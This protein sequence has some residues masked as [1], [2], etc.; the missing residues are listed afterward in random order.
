MQYSAESHIRLQKIHKL[1]QN[2]IIPYSNSFG[3]KTDIKDILVKEPNQKSDFLLQNGANG[4]YRILWRMILSRSHG[5]LSFAKIIDNTGSIQICLS[6][7]L[8]EI[9]NGAKVSKTIKIDENEI[10]AYNFFGKYVDVGDYVWIIGDFFVT[11]HWEKTLFVKTFS[12]LSKAIR[13]LPDKFHGINDIEAIYKQRYLDLITNED[14]YRRFVFRSEFVRLIREFYHQQ[15]F[16]E[17]TTPTLGNSASGAAAKPFVTYHND[18]KQN[19]FLRIAPEIAL[20]KATVWRFEKVF[21]FATNFRN[22]WSDPSHMQ[23]FCVVEHYA[24]WRN[25]EDNMIFTEKMFD[26]IFDKT[27]LSRNIKVKD[28]QWIEKVVDFTTPRQRIDYIKW[29]KEACGI[30]ISIYQEW[31]EKKLLADIIAKW[32]KFE[33]MEIMWVPTLIDYLYKKVLRPSIVWPAFVYNYPKVMQPLARQ[34]D[35]NPNIVEQFQLVVNGR[36]LN[37]AYSELVDPEIQVA[38]FISQKKAIQRWDEEATDGD[39]D[40]VL[41]MEYGMPPQS[42]FG[43]GIERA[44]SILLEQENLRDTYLFPLTKSEDIDSSEFE[45]F[46]FTKN[47]SDQKFVN[48]TLDKDNNFHISFAFYEEEMQSYYQKLLKD[49]KYNIIEN[50]IIC[51]KDTILNGKNIEKFTKELN[52]KLEKVQIWLK[53]FDQKIDFEFVQKKLSDFAIFLISQKENL[54]KILNQYETNWVFDDEFERSIDLLQ[55]IDENKEYFQYKVEQIATFLPKNQ[56]L[57]A[58]V[59][60][61]IVPSMMTE[62]LVVR[63]PKSMQDFFDD[64]VTIL[65]IAK[66][67]PNIKICDMSR[68]QYLDLI[69]QNQNIKWENLPDTDV[70]IFTGNSDHSLELK[71]YFGPKTLFVTNGSWHNP[72]VVSQDANISNTVDAICDLQLYNQWQDCASPNCILVDAKIYDDFLEKLIS[73]IQTYTVWDYTN[74]D[75]WPITDVYMLRDINDLF[76]TNNKY[77]NQKLPNCAK[78]EYNKKL[79]YPTIIQKDLNLWWN[80]KELFAP[81]FFVQKYN[82]NDELRQYFENDKYKNNAMYLTLYGK[83]D[84]IFGLIDQKIEWIGILH[85]K[86]TFLHDRHLH[87]KWIERWT[88]PYWWYGLYGSN[89]T[90]LGKTYYK[91]T[92]PQ[93]DIYE[94]LIKND[95]SK[96]IEIK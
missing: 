62:R 58:F 25:Y 16:V 51:P 34:S 69:T 33:N 86:E 92:L 71:K 49:Q 44:L 48:L 47:I 32:I 35:Q 37:K 59:C 22:E 18:F 11:N 6:K 1:K 77:L 79:V 64:F 17:I 93:R 7:W 56:V 94:H 27:W 74:A 66:Y 8:V 10:D 67:F 60:F 2:G 31:D 13:P 81:I 38:N 36:E 84:Y 15:W 65:D 73:K 4:D 39:Y 23:E 80:Y 55:N 91:P 50:T 90:F 40:F 63:K 85:T 68:S 46:Y 89:I 21:E 82:N 95:I 52:K 54:R 3:N 87:Q 12:I 24:V 83:N 26:Y 19:M 72:V 30:D 42:G 43:M 70:V 29:V 9:Q 61:C 76:V 75:I 96:M 20:K 5:K 57:Y 53:S 45:N 88:Q 78:I 41:A 28:K 14:S